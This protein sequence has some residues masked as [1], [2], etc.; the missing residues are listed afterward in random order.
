[1]RMRTDEYTGEQYDADKWY[2][3]VFGAMRQEERV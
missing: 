3:A 2:Q 1:M